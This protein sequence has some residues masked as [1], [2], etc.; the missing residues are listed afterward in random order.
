MYYIQNNSENFKNI[1][2][3]IDKSENAHFHKHHQ[4]QQ[5]DDQHRKKRTDYMEHKGVH[6]CDADIHSKVI[7]VG[8]DFIIT[9]YSS[10]GM[11]DIGQTRNMA[12]V[13]HHKMILHILWQLKTATAA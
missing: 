9:I 6:H 7:M 1:H 10:Y 13:W 5:Q 8:G 12:I 3:V 11:R 2:F 4:Q